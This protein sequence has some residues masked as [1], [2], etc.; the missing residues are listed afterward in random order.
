MY[1]EIEVVLYVEYLKK[2]GKSLT[3]R[4]RYNAIMTGPNTVIFHFAASQLEMQDT[5]SI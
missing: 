4:Y 5:K 2:C 1:W 3:G